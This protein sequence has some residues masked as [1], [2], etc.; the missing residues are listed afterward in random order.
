MGERLL[1]GSSPGDT[2]GNPEQFLCPSC[3]S[4]PLLPGASSKEPFVSKKASLRGIFTASWRLGATGSFPSQASGNCRR[5][6]EGRMCSGALTLG[7]LRGDESRTGNLR[8]ISLEEQFTLK[9]KTRE[10]WLW[11]HT[12]FTANA[13]LLPC[14]GRIPVGDRI[15]FRAPSPR[16]AELSSGG[17]QRVW[18]MGCF[19]WTTA[20]SEP[21]ITQTHQ[22]GHLEKHP[23]G[24]CPCKSQIAHLTLKLE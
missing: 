1:F 20:K 11:N 23:K 3:G 24:T 6:G 12:D 19:T 5:F 2:A 22:H 4:C 18:G 10:V 16:G 14:S 8:E 21:R 15:T 9:L 17:S 13:Q 7:L